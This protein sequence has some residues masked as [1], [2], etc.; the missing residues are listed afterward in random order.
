[1]DL[2]TKKFQEEIDSIKDDEDT[3][4]NIEAM[5][6]AFTMDTGVDIKNVRGALKII[7]TRNSD[8]ADKL[9]KEFGPKL[10][11]DIG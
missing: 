10:L 4:I 7:K 2:L 8:L 3:T 1:M 9:A 6:W 5:F 11:V